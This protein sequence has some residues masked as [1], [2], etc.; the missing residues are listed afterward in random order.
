MIYGKYGGTDIE[1][2]GD[3]V[4]I[5]RESD[6]LAKVLKVSDRNIESAPNPLAKHKEP[7]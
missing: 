4:K 6:I 5:L 1:I 7:R 3:D 2:D